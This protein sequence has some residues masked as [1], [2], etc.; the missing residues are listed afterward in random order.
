M[1]NNSDYISKLYEKNTLMI[2]YGC[3]HQ[4]RFIRLVLVNS[5]NTYDDLKSFF[6]VLESFV[7]EYKGIIKRKNNKN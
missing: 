7:E 4:K 3:F 6:E 1:Q 2:G 5:E